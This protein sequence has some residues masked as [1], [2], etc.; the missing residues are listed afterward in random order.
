V[1]ITFGSTTTDHLSHRV[2]GAAAIRMLPL[3]EHT[4]AVLEIESADGTKNILYLAAPEAYAL[5]PGR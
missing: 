3:T 4:G 2:H 1:R 5:P